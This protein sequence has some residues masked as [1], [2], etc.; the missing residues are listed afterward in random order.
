MN[1]EHS[2]QQRC[3]NLYW[4]FWR[5]WGSRFFA[6]MAPIFEIYLAKLA[7]QRWWPLYIVQKPWIQ[8]GSGW[9]TPYVFILYQM[10]NVLIPWVSWFLRNVQKWCITFP[11]VSREKGFLPQQSHITLSIS[12]HQTN[13]RKAE[14][15]F[16]LEN[17]NQTCWIDVEYLKNL[18]NA[19][20]WHLPRWFFSFG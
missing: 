20:H 5:F 4:L 7:W 19:S 11:N 13:G 16:T 14:R 18:Q 2:F 10:Y 9:T 6:C 8:G 12:P 15:I 3:K 17:F 1:W